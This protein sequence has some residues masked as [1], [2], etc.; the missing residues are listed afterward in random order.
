MAAA[1]RIAVFNALTA[2][3]KPFFKPRLILWNGIAPPLRQALE[4]R[5]RGIKGAILVT[6]VPSGP[7]DIFC[8]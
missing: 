1:N 7:D 5:E 3:L 4:P 2:Y 8:Q 6:K